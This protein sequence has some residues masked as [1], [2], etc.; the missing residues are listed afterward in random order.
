[1]ASTKYFENDD[2]DETSYK[3]D[4]T[5]CADP[6]QTTAAAFN[7]LTHDQTYL[8]N[9]SSVQHDFEVFADIANVVGTKMDPKLVAHTAYVEEPESSLKA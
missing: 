9:I 7:R 3:Q 4:E 2:T 8:M 1:M 6:S 5:E